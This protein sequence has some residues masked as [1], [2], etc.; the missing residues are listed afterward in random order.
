MCNSQIKCRSCGSAKRAQ[1]LHPSAAAHVVILPERQRAR[2]RELLF[3]LHVI[4]GH[5]CGM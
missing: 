5:I 3:L 4:K 1:P 2:Q